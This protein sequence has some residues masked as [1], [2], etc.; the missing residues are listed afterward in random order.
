MKQKHPHEGCKYE[1]AKTHKTRKKLYVV[2]IDGIVNNINDTA[3]VSEYLYLRALMFHIFYL[4][5]RKLENVEESDNILLIN[6][7]FEQYLKHRK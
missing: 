3:N 1:Y 4:L 6:C 5:F 2:N 7:N